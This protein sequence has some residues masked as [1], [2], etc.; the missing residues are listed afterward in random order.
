MFRRF[1]I[2][3]CI[4]LF[5]STAFAQ[6]SAD[7]EATVKAI[8]KLIAAEPGGKHNLDELRTLW[9]NDARLIFKTASGEFKAQPIDEFI[10]NSRRVMTSPGAIFDGGLHEDIIDFKIVV[11]G[12]VAQ[13]RVQYKMFVPTTSE[14][15]VQQGVDFV[16]LIKTADGWKVI[17]L[18]NQ[19]LSATDDPLPF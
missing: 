8:Y 9:H 12:D 5:G 19:R 18:S 10:E 6:D 1:T 16:E 17:Y 11:F 14:T 2:I 13:A 15:P 7:A 3:V 4:L